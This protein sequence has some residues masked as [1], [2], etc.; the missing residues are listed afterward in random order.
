MEPLFDLN[1]ELVGWIDPG[2]HIFDT[3][4]NW[5]A[6]IAND[7]AWSSQTGNWLGPV[8]GLNCLDQTGKP[9][10]W[11]PNESVEGSMRSMRPMRAMRAMRPMRPML[12]MRPM[13]PM[14]PMTPMG[15]WSQMDWAAWMGQ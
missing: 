7:H 3:D 9:I 13:R 15:G 8:N 10:A 5:V 4:M 14:R 6:Y 12:P 1:C 2:N 11:N